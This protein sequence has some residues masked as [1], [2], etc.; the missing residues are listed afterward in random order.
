MPSQSKMRVA[1]APAAEYELRRGLFDM[2]GSK[3]DLS[4]EP[5]TPSGYEGLCGLIALSGGAD[6]ARG[7]SE[8]GISCYQVNLSQ[9]ISLG[10]PSAI[11]FSSSIAVHGAFR[12]KT[13]ADSSLK[14]FSRVPDSFE[15]LANVG[16]QPVW[17]VEQHVTSQRHCVGVDV[18]AFKQ[19]EF[20]HTYFREVRWF[21]M[22]PLLHF[23]RTLLG[24]DGWPGPQ[25]RASFI[26]DDPNLHHRSYGYIDFE[27]LANHAAAHNYHAT[28]ATVP[29]DAWY[30]DR[31]VAD[32]FQTRKKHI[33]LMMHGVNHVADELA[34]SYE[35]Q[36]A[37]ALLAT[38]LRRISDLES[39]SGVAVAR[40][41]A[42]PHGA[43]AEF[44]ADLMVRLG[45]EAAC[46][47][48]GSLLRWNPEKLWPADLGFSLAQSLGSLAFPVF[49]RTG[50][51]ETDIRLSAFLGHPVIVATHHQD[52]VSNFARLESMA[53]I[54]NETPN[55]QWMGIEDISR[56]NFLSK[57][58][59]GILQIWPYSR[60]FKIAL[61]PEI[62]SLQVC[63]SPY[64]DG[65]MIDLRNN[66]QDG[67]ETTMPNVPARCKIL[68]NMIE[69]FFPPTDRVDY[70]QVASKRVGM[71]PIV[72]RLL[73]EARDRTKP[74]LSLAS[75]R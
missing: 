54:I 19:G 22:V 74:I 41:M 44:M 8:R 37:L 13:L 33:S 72:R 71:W 15:C 47:S 16:G 25:P 49:H 20:F 12:N 55:I 28:I 39:R 66:H 64:C 14:H 38:G 23:L 46:V 40:I 51:S 26:I 11:T 58:Q 9:P 21:S 62:T 70:N 43:F 42:A 1:V 63:R 10:A 67:T 34:R 4:F 31:K 59:N 50:I 56:T 52:C 27:K 65:F 48:I 57:T 2:L 53:D 69:V 32:L 30:F 24:P 17:A 6:A 45:Y 18:P 73:T 5:H 61:S 75:A 60:R 3:L 7:A 68:N 35:E 36:D 29:L